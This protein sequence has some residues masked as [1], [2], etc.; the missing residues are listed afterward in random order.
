MLTY[1]RRGSL[2]GPHL[3][4]PH[5]M[6]YPDQTAVDRE[7]S[8]C[9]LLNKTLFLFC[10]ILQT[11]FT[12]KQ[13]GPLEDVKKCLLLN[14]TPQKKASNAEKNMNAPSKGTPA[15]LG[16]KI[17]IVKFSLLIVSGSSLDKLKESFMSPSAES[18]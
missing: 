13:A 16:N 2:E 7:L 5:K 12:S 1:Y 6:F 8:G 17:I 14:E 9:V 4:S 3:A 18:R 11:F 15:Y 10:S